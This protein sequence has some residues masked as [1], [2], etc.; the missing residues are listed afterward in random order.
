MDPTVF[1]EWLNTLQSFEPKIFHPDFSLLNQSGIAVCIGIFV[2]ILLVIRRVFPLAIL[3]R[4]YL[5]VIA[6]Q[7]LSLYGWYCFVIWIAM[8]SEDKQDRKWSILTMGVNM[9]LYTLNHSLTS[10]CDSLVRRRVKEE[11]YKKALDEA[12]SLYAINAT[13]CREV[14]SDGKVLRS[15]LTLV[16]NELTLKGVNTREER[17]ENGKQAFTD[18]LMRERLHQNLIGSPLVQNLNHWR[19]HGE[20]Q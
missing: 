9:F 15:F 18:L 4:Y 6:S 19:G 12:V 11:F 17:L 10:S 16:H 2:F 1:V 3:S 20:Q 8:L 5:K 13:Q 7:A 14:T